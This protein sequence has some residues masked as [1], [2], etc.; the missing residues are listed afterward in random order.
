MTS[1]M[2]WSKAK[3]SKRHQTI[4]ESSNISGSINY[5]VALRYVTVL[6][7]SCNALT[8]WRVIIRPLHAAV[9]EHCNVARDSTSHHKILSNDSLV[10]DK[11]NGNGN[12]NDN[13]IANMNQWASILPEELLQT[14]TT[15]RLL[16]IPSTPSTVIPKF[17]DDGG[18]HLIEYS[19]KLLDS[20]DIIGTSQLRLAFYIDRRS[21]RSDLADT[22]H[23]SMNM[24]KVHQGNGYSLESLKSILSIMFSH[25][26]KPS[27]SSGKF[28]MNQRGELWA[29]IESQ[30]SPLL[31][32]ARD[33]SPSTSSRRGR[34]W[35]TM[36]YLDD[37]VSPIFKH[38][39]VSTSHPS[40]AI[41]IKR[42]TSSS[43][44]SPST[45][46][47]PFDLF[48]SS[49]L[50][51]SSP[52]NSPT[53]T[54][55][56]PWLKVL[57]IRRVIATLLEGETDHPTPV[58]TT[59]MEIPSSPRTTSRAASPSRTAG[60]RP[61]IPQDSRHEEFVFFAGMGVKEMEAAYISTHAS[62]QHVLE[63]LGFAFSGHRFH[64]LASGA[65][66]EEED[67]NESDEVCWGRW[68]LWELD[69]VEFMAK[70]FHQEEEDDE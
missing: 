14:I 53:L 29:K 40:S 8:N 3:T 64:P 6:E 5:N 65:S 26:S 70:W 25:S 34:S 42:N 11:N 60:P 54:I 4:P 55:K 32:P 22:A 28:G 18:Y 17:M 30:M 10:N 47:T 31:T 7:S 62:A 41:D 51:F 58:A 35:D 36:S 61:W 38:L 33:P 21:N 45:P 52:L 43:V 37:D 49:S 9:E 59:P 67:G 68:A 46:L 48:P 1:S 44:D 15:P 27:Q 56:Q 23:I 69:R 12:R 16:L 39:S 19:A 66:E 50:R 57:S 13:A 24:K 20:Q 2:T 63:K